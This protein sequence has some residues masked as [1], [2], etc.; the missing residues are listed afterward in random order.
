MSLTVA[1]CN[2]SAPPQRLCMT[3]SWCHAQTT[4]RS[5]WGYTARILAEANGCTRPG[6]IG[7][8]LR[9]GCTSHLE[10]WQ[11]ACEKGAL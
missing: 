4:G 8:F 5:P 11:A 1:T 6:Q 9:R 7:E 10:K 3:R 2:S